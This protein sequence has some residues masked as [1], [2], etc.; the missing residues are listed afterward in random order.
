MTSSEIRSSFLEFFEKRGHRVVPSAPVIPHGD[1]TLLFTNAGM[2]QFKDVFLG[3]GERPYTRA[4]DT[5]KC[6]RVSGKH[7]DL[8]EVGYDTYHHTFFEMLG[9]WSFGDYFKEEAIAWSWELLTEVWKLPANRLHATVFRTDDEAY[10]I[11]RKYLPEGQ[12]HRFDEKDNFWE[13]GETGPCGP[14]SEIH[15]DNTPN[16]S[17]ATLVN[18]G[19]PEVIEIW[20]NVFIQYNRLADGSLEDLPSKHV[21]TGMGFE[22]ITAVMQNKTSN[23]DTDVFQPIINLTEE[24]SGRKYQTSLTN[25]DGIAMR[26]IADHVRTLCFAI[27]DGAIPGN[28]GRGYVLRR[29][30][31]RAARYAKNLGLHEA[32]L[33]KHVAVVVKTMGGVFP[34]LIEHQQLI[35]RV[36][37]AEEDSFLAT[38]ER[39]LARFEQLTGE[40]ISGDVAFELYDTFGFPLDLTQLLAKERGMSVDDARFDVCLAEQR[41]RSRAARKSNNVSV[42]ANN[43]SVLSHFDG[44]NNTSTISEILYLSENEIVLAETPFYVEMGGQVSDTGVITIA[45]MEYAVEGM[46]KAGQAIVHVLDSSPDASIGDSV[47]AKVDVARRREINREHSATHLLHE[48]LREVLGTHVQQSGSLV[49]PN[50]LRFDFSHFEKIS[51]SEIDAIENIVNEKIFQ[52]IDVRTEEL[53]I[54]VA[55]TIPKV[56]MFFGDKYSDMVR[57]VFIDEKFSVE[58]CGGTHVRNTSEIGLFKIIS[59]SSIASGVRRIE[60]IAGRNIDGYI[61]QLGARIIQGESELEAMTDRLRG[62]EKQIAASQTTELKSAIPEMI[63]NATKYED[64]LLASARMSVPSLDQLKELGDDLRLQ[65]KSGGIGV[66]AAVIEDKA[67]LVCVVTDDL[68]SKYPAGKIVGALAKLMGGGG[69]GKPHLATAGGKDVSKLDQV[70]ASINDVISEIS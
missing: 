5:Q 64:Y 65:L 23:Y 4:V 67:Q 17:G 8:E 19:V 7:N 25:P 37:R 9:N 49:A 34:E 43:I 51:D 66:L 18:K 63:K 26:V 40:V 55:R 61:K 16:L 2:N 39:G 20:N 70:L 29:I 1:P 60:A 30:L 15:F 36:I 69:G 35:E 13:M 28:E 56:K 24:L 46:R 57:V 22:R 10:D 21:D 38:L 31:R 68:V 58:L 6:I 42:E 47:V 53:S 32:V 52:S 45:G 14:C 54:D 11:W 27:A 44:Y 12:I 50:H 3:Q 59:E 62:L 33:Y 48:A 41:A